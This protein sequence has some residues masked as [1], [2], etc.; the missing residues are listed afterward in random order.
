MSG[1]SLRTAFTSKVFMFFFFF[2]SLYE[3]RLVPEKEFKPFLVLSVSLEP[4]ATGSP[5][6]KA[7]VWRCLCERPLS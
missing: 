5:Q 6:R 1:T 3:I 4:G 7:L 2:F